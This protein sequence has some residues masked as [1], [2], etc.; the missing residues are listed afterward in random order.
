MENKVMWLGNVYAPQFETSSNRIRHKRQIDLARKQRFLFASSTTSRNL[1]QWHTCPPH[2]MIT[3]T[4]SVKE[5]MTNGPGP[6]PPWT[7]LGCFQAPYLLRGCAMWPQV[8]RSKQT[9]R[10]WCWSEWGGGWPRPDLGTDPTLEPARS[11]SWRLMCGLCDKQPLRPSWRPKPEGKSRTL[12]I[13]LYIINIEM[14]PITKIH[15]NS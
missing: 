8:W 10:Q 7:F 6:I 15:Y 9:R 5:Q 14:C 4:Y 3:F 13:S 12:N 11:G 2:A 1:C